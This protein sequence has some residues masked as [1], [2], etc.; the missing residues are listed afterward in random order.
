MAMLYG[1]YLWGVTRRVDPVIILEFVRR[2]GLAVD[3][4]ESFKLAEA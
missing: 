4:L 2:L 1:Y 3:E